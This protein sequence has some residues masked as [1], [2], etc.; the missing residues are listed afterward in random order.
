MMNHN[1][2]WTFIF[3]GLGLFCLLLSG[4]SMDKNMQPAIIFCIIG[5]GCVILARGYEMENNI[6]K[7]IL[8]EKI[9]KELGL[10][11][12]KGKIIKSI[13]KKTIRTR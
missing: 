1:E 10:N 7:T 11:V 3:V 4:Y 9:E 13:N 5:T 12:N 6:L 8:A 2:R